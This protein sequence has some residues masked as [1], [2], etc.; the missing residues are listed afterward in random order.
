MA[1]FRDVV[2][3]YRPYWSVALAS[4]VG[5][6]VFQLIDLVTP[7]TM[8]QILNALSGQPVD[9]IVQSLANWVAGQ[10]AHSPDRA[11]TIGALLG[12]IFLVTVVRAPIQPWISSWLN[13]STALR[14]RRDNFERSLEKL[15]SL[16]LKF[17]DDH[18]SGWVSS[19]ITNG[20]IN[21]TWAFGEVAGQLIPKLFRLLGI[22]VIVC[23]IEWKIAIVLITSF[24]VIL[25]LNLRG[26][27]HLIKQQ[28]RVEQYRE[29]TE[30][31]IAEIV[32]NIKTVKAFATERAEL[33]KQR[34][35]FD[36]EFKV[37]QHRVHTGFVKLNC[38]QNVL[39]QLCVFLVLSFTLYAAIRQE[40]SLGHFIT[41]F[42]ITNM[43][44]AELSPIHGLI[45]TLARRYVPML[46]FHELMEQPLGVDSP[47]TSYTQ[48]TPYQ[49]QGKLHFHSLNFSYDPKHEVLHDINL[50]IEPCQTIALIG[51]SGSGKSTLMKLL[52]RYF[53][54][55]Q[56]RI[57]IDGDDIRSL[58]IAEYRRRLA[59]VHQDVDLFNGTLLD[60]L[61]YGNPD[62]TFEQVQNACRIA[63]AD[64]FIQQLPK[65][66]QTPVG[67]RG[68]CLSGG[69]RQR[70]GIA[71]A[72]LMDPD[73]LIFDEATSSLDSESEQAIQRAMRSILG[74]R[75]TII[76]AHRLSTIREVDK[77]VV[78][79]RG[80]IAEVGSHE[81]LLYKRGLYYHLH[82]IQTSTSNE[83]QPLAS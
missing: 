69:Q 25:T 35:R 80:S 71:R 73:V 46:H 65:K 48:S 53:E 36:R 33:S 59:I 72:L 49:F 62:V 79:D 64:S 50:L 20:I 34:R 16:P 52:F 15:L 9:W 57:L 67:E 83:W 45:E 5:I 47:L 41:T 19:R 75:T 76:I 27:H 66:Y 82:S 22:F 43:A 12:V 29:S 68:M 51:R 14:A 21:H 10:T 78:L 60:N 3:Y 44:Y 2:G 42:T 61:T 58:D 17:Y 11:F 18:N 4:T 24:I 23:F 30:S 77:I 31:R 26:I 6:C 40:I 13:W 54:P 39:V 81:E 28:K 70:L 55:D 74:T 1:T 63:Q 38:R 56:G 32:T 8:G 37:L 7:Y